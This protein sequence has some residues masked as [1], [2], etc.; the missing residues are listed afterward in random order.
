MID[1]N[2]K[3]SNESETN[4]M[5]ILVLL[6]TLIFI[7]KNSVSVTVSNTITGPR[8]RPDSKLNLTA[9]GILT[10]YALMYSSFWFIII[11]LG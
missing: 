6:E 8:T 5:P 1:Y 4:R 2:R 7:K 3:L 11:N 9:I 10:L